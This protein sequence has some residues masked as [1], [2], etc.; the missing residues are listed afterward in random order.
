MV[1][2]SIAINICLL[3][4]SWNLWIMMF[5]CLFSSHFLVTLG[6]IKNDRSNCSPSHINLGYLGGPSA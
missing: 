4:G 1:E 2:S 3:E 5:G 6:I